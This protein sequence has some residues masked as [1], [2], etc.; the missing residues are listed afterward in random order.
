MKKRDALKY[1]LIRGMV[2]SLA[3]LP[4]GALY[5][6]SD[7]ASFLLHR[8]IKYRV[9]VVRKNLRAVFPEKEEKELLA[10][11]RDFYRHLC[12]IFIETAKL[13]HISDAE[14][15]RR[16]E[17]VD[18]GLVNEALAS[19]RSVVLMLGHYGN[20]EWVTSAARYFTQGVESCEI[21]H[22]LRDKAMDRLMLELRSRF[23]TENIP[24]SRAVRHLLKTHREGKLFV[25]GFISDQRPFTPELKHWTAFLGQDTA[26]V[27]GGE[28]IG[29][30]VD[31]AFIYVEMLPVGRGHYRMTF[32]RLKPLDDGEENPY[33][34]AFL[35]EL[36][37]SIRRNPSYWLW[38]H[39][40]W[41]RKRV[42]T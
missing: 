20:W 11:E 12:D 29:S 10:I 30:K 34:L 28:A 1:H 14:M 15:D 7:A 3:I 22:A 42:Q 2:K 4:L 6:L 40:R 39:N 35:R 9:G 27:N 8:V 32:R 21:Y 31:A 41:K 25:C 23:G 5:G 37:G 13:A 36:E 38:S 19:G 26:Y 24:M 18:V 17:Y 33:T 16:V